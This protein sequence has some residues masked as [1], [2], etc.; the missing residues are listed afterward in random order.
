MIII[1]HNCYS[2]IFRGFTPYGGGHTTGRLALVFLSLL[3]LTLMAPRAA[4]Q[5]REPPPVFTYNPGPPQKVDLK[6]AV[7]MV[8]LVTVFFV[9]GFLSVY[10]RRCA[11]NGFQGHGDLSLGFGGGAWAA[12]GLDSDIIETFPTFVYSTVK[13][14]KLG[15]GSLECAVCLNEFQDNETLRLIPKCDHV[16][17]PDCIDAWLV[18]HSTCPVCRA[19]LVPK[20]GESPNHVI[21]TLA[22]MLS[23]NNEPVQADPRTGSGE[24]ELN[25]QVSIRVEEKEKSPEINLSNPGGPATPN[26]SRPPR[27]RSTGFGPPRS[28]STGWRFGGLFPRS[29]STGHSLVRQGE[30]QERFTLR[31]PEDVRNQLV[32]STLNRAKSSG[33]A[34]PRVGSARR[35][36]RSVSGGIG[37][38]KDGSN[39]YE[40]FEPE[41][42]AD[43][44]VF[45]VVPPFFSR[46][47]SVRSSKGI[48]GG[49]GDVATRSN[50]A[51]PA[52]KE[53][54]FDRVYR[55]R[56]DVG[57]RSSDPL[58]LDDQ[59]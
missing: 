45:S 25:R 22:D 7:V 16:F 9:L 13:G 26:Q 8:L 19:N 12:R 11:V 54:P 49:G 17:H 43:R 42:Q 34:L 3:L 21:H 35:G 1:N 40:R 6:M 51:S 27:S 5:N 30:S 39:Y 20:P 41:G 10:T 38:R 59:V 46:I 4:A 48:G 47:G 31:L 56:D 28:R 33:A 50:A 58:R 15:K 32:N 18:S 29:F 23:P 57:E 52:S 55:G 53:L 2:S 36:F 44:W 24:P 37:L 14:L